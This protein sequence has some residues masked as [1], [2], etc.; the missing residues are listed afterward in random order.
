MQPATKLR[1]E[2]SI[3]S[4]SVKQSRVYDEKRSWAPHLKHLMSI[5]CVSADGGRYHA[6]ANGQRRYTSVKEHESKSTSASC[7]I[8]SPILW[9]PRSVSGR[10]TTASIALRVRVGGTTETINPTMRPNRSAGTRE[11][12]MDC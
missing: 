6:H 4:P 9:F 12:R 8:C 11:D 2:R 3:W 1:I 5:A 7:H 10:D